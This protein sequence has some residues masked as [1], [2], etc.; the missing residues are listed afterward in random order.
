MGSFCSCDAELEAA[1]MDV[2]GGHVKDLRSGARREDED[3]LGDLGQ[4]GVLGHSSLGVV[5]KM[6]CRDGNTLR[7]VKR[8]NKR[9]LQSNGWRD[10][11]GTILRMDHPHVCKLHDAV[12]DTTSVYLVMD[13]CQGGDLINICD[14][15]GSFS[16]G[17]VAGLVRQMAGAVAHLH[18]HAVVHSDIRPENWLFE[19]PVKAETSV[20]DMKLKMIDF[21]L[22]SKY[23][24]RRARARAAC[25]RQGSKPLQPSA[26]QPRTPPSQATSRRTSKDLRDLHGSICCFAPEQLDGF[27]DGKADVWALGI[28]SYFLLSGQTPFDDT[29][30]VTTLDDHLSFRNARFVF[31]PADI[32]R[33]VSA[34]AKNFVALCLHKD[35]DQRPSAE[36][37]LGL[38]W[39][40]LAKAAAEDE[41]VWLP[42]QVRQDNRWPPFFDRVLPTSEEVLGSLGRLR[43][44]QVLEKAAIFIIAR[45]LHADELASLERQ[46]ESMDAKKEG[47]LLMTEI[48]DTLATNWAV[49][50]ADIISMVEEGDIDKVNCAELLAVVAEFQRNV[51]DAAISDIFR[52]FDTGEQSKLKRKLA[53]ACLKQATY[54]KNIE[55]AFPRISMKSIQ[56]ALQ[57]SPN[58]TVDFDELHNIL[59]K[60]KVPR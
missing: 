44:S 56:E 43:R 58:E 22:A 55:D 4:D 40:R 13:L 15:V 47:I 49:K 26:S 45:S 41:I 20:R 53:A 42:S 21:G 7:A 11:V 17:T 16:E 52:A 38:P 18:E 2:Q 1:D 54:Q 5:V 12:E 37:M 46:F 25:G 36:Q 6:R 48:L 30:G 39:M 3:L 60:S 10:E 57:S 23:G 28:L 14:N 34:E 51:Q 9:N 24:R 35:P 32:W 50:C 33:P 59:R 8:I 29:E 31:M 27:A 19:S